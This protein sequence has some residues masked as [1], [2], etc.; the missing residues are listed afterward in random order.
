MMR[1]SMF[2]L[3]TA[4]CTCLLAPVAYLLIGRAIWWDWFS[5]QHVLV[6]SLSPPFRIL[7][8]VLVSWILVVA[9]LL[10]CR[11]FLARYGRRA[12]HTAWIRLF[13]TVTMSGVL[14]LSP[15]FCLTID[16]GTYRD[17]KEWASI[18][19]RVI[20]CVP[21]CAVVT[22]IASAIEELVARVSKPAVR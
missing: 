4:L 15:E 8:A 2:G 1:S 7:V 20:V 16:H 13:Q 18:E 3:Y 17:V 9:P 10:L 11:L 21:A 6:V 22:L 12:I 5:P 19:F 14:C